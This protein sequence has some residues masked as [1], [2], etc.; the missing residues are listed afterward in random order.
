MRRNLAQSL[1]DAW[2]FVF[3]FAENVSV[4][5]FN[6]PRRQSLL[7]HII[8]CFISLKPSSTVFPPNCHSNSRFGVTNSLWESRST[9]TVGKRMHIRTYT[10]TNPIQKEKNAAQLCQ[11]AA[12]ALLWLNSMAQQWQYI[13]SRHNNSGSFYSKVE[14]NQNSC[15]R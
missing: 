11:K 14:K 4:V 13:V 8:Y 3:A 5:F 10:K 2:L 6:R 7:F 15:S 1:H 9:S 12:E